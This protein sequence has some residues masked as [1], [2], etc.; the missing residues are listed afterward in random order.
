VGAAQQQQLLQSRKPYRKRQ[1]QF[2]DGISDACMGS[3]F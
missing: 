1:R 2:L 3:A